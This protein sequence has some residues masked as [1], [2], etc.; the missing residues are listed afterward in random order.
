MPK[1]R[2]P[3]GR[4]RTAAQRVPQGREITSGTTGAFAA[5]MHTEHPFAFDPLTLWLAQVLTEA[6]NAAREAHGEAADLRRLAMHFTLSAADLAARRWTRCVPQPR[7]PSWAHFEVAAWLDEL[8]R[9]PGWGPE[10][11]ATAV[12][13]LLG[14]F[15]FLHRRGKLD[16]EVA[17]AHLARLEHH[18]NEPLRRRGYRPR[19]R[20]LP[21]TMAP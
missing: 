8:R 11:Q 18:I 5:V 20:A 15:T 4:R 7:M 21:G 3:G 16:A 13:S 12:A 10:R 17:V 9:E 14:F 1:W 19:Y 6:R 2:P